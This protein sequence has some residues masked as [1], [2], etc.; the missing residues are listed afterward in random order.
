MWYNFQKCFPEEWIKLTQTKQSLWSRLSALF[1][2]QD[3]T[4]GKP[5]VCLLKFSIPMLIGNIAQ[6][7]YS[8]VDSIVVGKYL[9]DAALSAIGASGPL[10]NL[11]LVVFMA[12][13]AGVGVMVSQ[14]YG[15]KEVENLGNSIGNAITLIFLFSLGITAIATP[16]TP[17]LLRLLNTPVETFD[18]AKAYLVILFIGAAGNGFYNVLSGVLRGLGEALFPFIVLVCTSLLNVGLDIWFVADLNM[19]IGGAALATIISQILSSIVCLIKILTMRRTVT[20][21]VK[22]LRLRKRIV[23]QIFR[24]GIPSGISMGVMFIGTLFVQSL[25]NRM[26][27][28]VTAAITAMIRLDG[29]AILPSQSFSM[30]AA[31]FTG[32][33]VGAN[34]DDR[35]KQGTKTVM[36]IC[37]TFTAVMV[38]CMHLFGRHLIRLFTDTDL[39]INM[40]MSFIRIL[41][42][43]YLIMVISNC[44]FGV[45]RGAGDTLGPMWISLMGNVGLRI[46]F[47]YLLASLTVS[48]AYPAGNPTSIF[49]SMLIQMGIVAVVT[50]IYFRKGKWKGKAIT[51]KGTAE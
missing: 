7:L 37:F 4:V 45:M 16:L 1:Q 34:R 29:F 17:A 39:V 49:F 18:M 9:G 2:A 43:G 21:T 48:A 20:I 23:K 31:T 35:V 25:I 32:Q 3:M 14:Y 38:V 10:Q 33:N 24:L 36:T 19:G 41:T 15:A 28:L 8:T 44:L 40:C 5:L 11:F 42:P 50:I 46:P 13:G 22:M 47:A 6:M 12:I 26:G 27:Y 51:G 30:A